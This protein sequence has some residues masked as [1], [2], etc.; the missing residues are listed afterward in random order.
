MTTRLWN[1]SLNRRIILLIA[2]VAMVGS[3]VN[4]WHGSEAL[5]S[6][7]EDQ[8]RAEL[9]ASA[10]GDAQSLSVLL[11]DAITDLE[12][13][14]EVPAVH[15]SVVTGDDGAR[16]E[17]SN[18]LVGV[19]SAKKIHSAIGVLDARGR[20][21]AG[22]E[23]EGSVARAIGADRLDG[24]RP[25]SGISGA[26]GNATIVDG[27]SGRRLVLQ[28]PIR[29]GGLAASVVGNVS[30]D[31]VSSAITSD[32]NSAVGFVVDTTGRWVIPPA[33][34]DSSFDTQMLDRLRSSVAVAAAS[35]GRGFV[36]EEGWVA[37]YATVVP[38]GGASN[39][40]WVVADVESEDVMFAPAADY[41]A[42]AV[43]WMVMLVVVMSVGATW[44][45]RRIVVVP[46]ERLIAS[47][48]RIGRGDLT[49]VATAHVDVDSGDEFARLSGGVSRL[50]DH[51]S[52]V[53]GGVSSTS[54]EV[55]SGSADVA[56]S[57]R[58]LSDNASQS[59]ASIEQMSA[60]MEE[61]ANKTRQNAANAREA[62]ELGR[63]ARDNAEAGDEQMKS[64]VE[65]MRDIDESARNISRII[66]VIDEIAFQTNLLALNAAVEA[67]RAGAHGKGFAVVAE[68]VRNLAERS[69]EAA[70]ETTEL[71][72][73]S[74]ARVDLGRRT[75][76]QMADSLT[77]IVES[78][79]RSADLVAEITV[80]SEE[81]AEGISQVNAG[82]TQVDR[83]TQENTSAAD[84]MSRAAADLEG[85]ADNVRQSLSGFVL[86]GGSRDA[87]DWAPTP[88]PAP[89]RKPEASTP[90]MPLPEES[91]E[92]DSQ[93]NFDGWG[94]RPAGVDTPSLDDLLG[95]DGESVDATDGWGHEPAVVDSP[96][97]PVWDDRPSD[98]DTPD[99]S[100]WGDRPTDVDTPDLSGWGE[101]AGD[102]ADA[103]G[104][105]APEEAAAD[106][107]ARN[108]ATA[109][110][111]DDEEFGR[112]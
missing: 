109:S 56:R 68:E 33:G 40:R 73:G 27:S 52:S 6:V 58:D 53:L 28:V 13:V 7:I 18:L 19:M 61:M 67:A 86:E 45:L 99:V 44:C 85:L 42:G 46:F 1:N 54:S 25:A 23:R 98:V 95:S 3:G 82:L 65:S 71:I 37:A 64:M 80:A 39:V 88:E 21:A 66:K 26:A 4:T 104:W 38:H 112:Y 110:S 78:I 34:A 31:A 55:A 62:M 50:V 90:P 49:K 79:S 70:R 63:Q 111:L 96:D 17:A 102:A 41:R 24:W 14:A 106:G 22:A 93:G 97:A 94:A 108:D 29:S 77:A 84:Q 75:A 16:D 35:G 20:A 76:E 83:V 81:Q 103:G 11:G 72:E 100:G 51:F 47:I 87:E 43:A 59:A 74:T 69:A 8:A 2:A 60:T 5:S 92:F 10:S 57:S 32:S 30:L 105:S 48:D 12:L 91:S 107:R 36:N 9:L 89:L 15:A 101:D